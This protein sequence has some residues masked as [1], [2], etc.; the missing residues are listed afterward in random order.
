[1]LLNV[2]IFG[3]LTLVS[4][5]NTT[6]ETLKTKIVIVQHLSCYKQLKFHTQLS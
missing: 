1:M 3:I 4:I 6:I 2:T 5:I